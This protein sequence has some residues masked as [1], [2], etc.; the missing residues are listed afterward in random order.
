MP[1]LN[2]QV[3]EREGQFPVDGRP[4]RRIGGLDDD[5]AVQ[6]HL[7]REVFTHVRVVPIEAGVGELD[8]AAVRAAHRDRFLRLVRYTV[9]AVLQPQ[10]V[11]V[12]GRFD[13]AAVVRPA[14]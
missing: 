7:L 12:H 6:A 14:R 3:V 11:P 13:I 8:L 2:Q 1:V 10:A 4:V 5:R 9:I